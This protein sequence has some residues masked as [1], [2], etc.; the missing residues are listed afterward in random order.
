MAAARPLIVFHRNSTV[1]ALA[2][3]RVT[4]LLLLRAVSRLAGATLASASQ[5]QVDWKDRRA[6]QRGKRHED[7]SRCPEGEKK[8]KATVSRQSR[9]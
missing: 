3:A 8:I 9:R 7:Q 6:G 5:W 2:A 1:F 4:P